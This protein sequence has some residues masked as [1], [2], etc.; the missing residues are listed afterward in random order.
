MTALMRMARRLEP[1]AMDDPRLDP[2]LHRQALA[3]LARLN[4][5]ASSDAIVW[6]ALRPWLTQ[7]P[8]QGKRWRLLDLACGGGDVTLALWRHARQEQLPLDVHGCDISPVALELSTQRAAQT[9]AQDMAF[10]A[11]D[12]IH[13]PLPEGYDVMVCSLF[14]HHL[15]EPQAVALLRKMSQAAR[16]VLIH[17]L[18]R[19]RP[20]L[21]LTW[22]STRLLTRSPVVRA[23][24][25][26]SVRAA[27]TPRE[28]HTL[29]QQAGLAGATVQQCFPYRM[30]LRWS[31]A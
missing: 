3:E 8:R 19:S 15:D 17:D 14:L 16:F 2:A 22:L 31:R 13:Q 28:L 18:V 7:A 30:V 29:A 23:D 4:R 12:V 10:F 5:L 20:G 6:R 1:E 11:C 26:Q 9:G 21:W 24:G 27:W 25:P